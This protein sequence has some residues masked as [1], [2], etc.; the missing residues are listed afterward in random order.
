MEPQPQLLLSTLHSNT[1]QQCQIFKRNIIQHM[2]YT[3]MFV[4]EV[5]LNTSNPD[6]NSNEE[7]VE[8][9]Q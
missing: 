7:Q 8:L 4:E 3:A 5:H 9:A 1:I 2:N 6:V